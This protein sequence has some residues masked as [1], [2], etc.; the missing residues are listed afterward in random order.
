MRRRA[1]NE[2]CRPRAQHRPYD[3]SSSQPRPFRPIRTR[4]N[5]Q[6]RPIQGCAA[7]RGSIPEYPRIRIPRPAHPGPDICL[8]GRGQSWARSARTPSPEG[9]RVDGRRTAKNRDTR[10]TP[11]SFVGRTLETVSRSVS[12]TR[13]LTRAN[14]RVLHESA[15]KSAHCRGHSGHSQSVGPWFES[16]RAHLGSSFS[17]EAGRS[18]GRHPR[19]R[20]KRGKRR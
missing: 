12:P 11:R 13:H 9:E 8:A 6:P 14:P 19:D 2:A 4:F 5:T 7:S 10:R 16:R 20:R 15:C 18:S 17:P 3:R 1:R